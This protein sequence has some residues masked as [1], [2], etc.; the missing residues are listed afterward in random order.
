MTDHSN[1]AMAWARE[2]YAADLRRYG[3]LSD[4]DAMTAFDAGA[5]SVAPC[6]QPERVLT[7]SEFLRTAEDALVRDKHG[8]IRSIRSA[9]VTDDGPYVLVYDPSWP[10][11]APAPGPVRI[12][13]GR[14]RAGDVLD[15]THRVT[16]TGVGDECDVRTDDTQSSH[17]LH[18]YNVTAYL[19]SRP[20]TPD[21]DAL[22]A[23]AETLT[24][25]GIDV[26][27]AE[28][29]APVILANLRGLGL[30]KS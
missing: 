6:R 1:A 7:T 15:V 16:V 21:A 22:H 29:D 19:V 17:N 20:P 11:A 10:A 9:R 27:D 28:D 5:A 2:Q 25:I 8:T 12:G 14:V 30:I 23:I 24:M 3:H 13:A 4:G 26:E 18:A